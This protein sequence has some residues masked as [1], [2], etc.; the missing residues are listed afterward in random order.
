MFEVNFE[1]CPVVISA[2]VRNKK[3][4]VWDLKFWKIYD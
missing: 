4:D 1:L 3:F 2:F